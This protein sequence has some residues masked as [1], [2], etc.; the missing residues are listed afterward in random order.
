M[1]WNRYI[2]IRITDINCLILLLGPHGPLMGV[3]KARKP[4]N[5]QNNPGNGERQ[6][7][8]YITNNILVF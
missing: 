2:T 7:I 5:Y 8:S 3:L 4:Q 1:A 6:D